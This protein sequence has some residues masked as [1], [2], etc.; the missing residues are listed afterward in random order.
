M[1][2]TR[3]FLIAVL[4][5]YAVAPLCGEEATYHATTTADPQIP[6]GDL[7]LLLK[8]L[9]KHELI[10]ETEAWLAL[11]QAKVQE[12]SLAEIEMKQKGREISEAKQ[13]I[14]EQIKEIKEDAKP[15]ADPNEAPT[16]VPEANEPAA[17]VEQEIQQKLETIDE[18]T[19]EIAEAAEDVNQTAV[20]DINTADEDEVRASE[21]DLLEKTEAVEEAKEKLKQAAAEVGEADVALEEKVKKIG[22]AE[23]ELYTKV[24]EQLLA[25]IN[26]LREEQT[27]LID[28][29]RVVVAALEAKGGDVAE[30]QQYVDAVSGLRV[31]VKDISATRAIILGWLRSPEG[32]LRWARSIASFMLIVIA[33]K[34]LSF[35]LGRLTRKAVDMN[36][37][38]SDLLGDFLVNIVRKA[39]FIIGLVIAL[40]VL[41]VN[42]GPLV[43]GIAALGFIIGFALQ[44]TLGN[45]AAGLMILLHRPYDVG[46]VVQ[47]AGITG[48]V[49]SMNLNT[50]TIKTFD[51]QVVVVPNGSIWGDNIVNVT[52]SDTRR[53]DLMFGIGYSDD[54]GKAQGILEEILRSHPLVLDEPV[55]NVKV[56][57]LGD[58]SVNY[59]CRPWTKTS[60]YW[61]VYWDVTRSV[62]ERFDAEGV[63]IPFPQRDVH[64]FQEN[65]QVFPG[66]KL[67]RDRE[68]L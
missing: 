6:P 26:R 59:I 45:F 40:S 4:A 34:I 10:V 30:Y 60:D 15:T 61:T 47:T 35:I 16:S 38:C 42:I 67:V 43:G 2:V 56:H 22:E 33:A 36:K 31:D 21:K 68:N 28:R 63:S 13:D 57:E 48:F 65:A 14:K 58:S 50:T 19:E 1:K 52:G 51:N 12:I 37:K 5:L 55:P 9:R 7:E 8:P 53:V 64:L 54:M 29:V 62:K 11:L 27:A 46:D 18:K 23:V 3:A 20:A 39:V 24:R 49:Q 25:H 44:G 17:K 32:G 41:G 66:T